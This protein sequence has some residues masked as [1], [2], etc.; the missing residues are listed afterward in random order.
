MHRILVVI[1]QEH[2]R[3]KVHTLAGDKQGL[4]SHRQMCAQ[5]P[6]STIGSMQYD[7]SKLARKPL[8]GSKVILIAFCKIEIGNPGSGY[9]VIHNLKSG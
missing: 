5:K 3:S 6:G 8:G 2:E 4:D 9:V 7:P 1:V